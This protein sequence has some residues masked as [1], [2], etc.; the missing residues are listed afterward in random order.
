MARRG[1][2]ETELRRAHMGHEATFDAG[3]GESSSRR[4]HQTLKWVGSIEESSAISRVY[5]H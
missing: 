3:G 2:R 5:V 4:H 1:N